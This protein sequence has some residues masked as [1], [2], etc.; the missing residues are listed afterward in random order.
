VVSNVTSFTPEHARLELQ[1]RKPSEAQSYSEAEEGVFPFLVWREGETGQ[2]IFSLGAERRLTIGR[3]ASCDIVLED[4]R[5]SRVHAALEPIAGDWALIDGAVSRNGTYVN[6][7]RTPSRRLADD[8]LLRLGDTYLLYRRPRHRGSVPTATA[9]SVS[10]LGALTDTQRTILIELA[11]PCLH[12]REHA[13]P[14]SNNA[15][16]MEM[17]LSLDAVRG[18]LDVLYGRF[19]VA[20]LT[21]AERRVRLVECAF[22]WG[23]ITEQDFR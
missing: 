14:A 5:V 13:T 3:R 1:P 10:D 19:E 9:S 11:R 16:A 15:I 2:R 20:D 7:E 23:V 8:D 12:A 22:R 17:R 21:S 6:G 18:H 4:P